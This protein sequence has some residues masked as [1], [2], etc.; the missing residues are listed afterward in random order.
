MYGDF[1]NEGEIL[2]RDTSFEL[3][4]HPTQSIKIQVKE[5]LFP[6]PKNE[7]EKFIARVVL[8]KE[9]KECSGTGK[10]ETDALKHCLSKI[11]DVSDDTIFPFDPDGRF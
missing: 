1:I 9:F 8:W 11:K 10:T 2:T 4:R 7:N 6:A 5:I 3:M